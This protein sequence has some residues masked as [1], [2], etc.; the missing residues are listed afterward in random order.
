[1]LYNDIKLLNNNCILC[2]VWENIYVKSFCFGHGRKWLMKYQVFPKNVI[3][4][5][6]IEDFWY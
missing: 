5:K 2:F 6:F 4:I 1:M 3:I